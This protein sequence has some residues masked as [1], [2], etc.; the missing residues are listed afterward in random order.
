MKRMRN[1]GILLQM[2]W[3]NSPGYFA[4]LFLGGLVN[5]G[6]V[7]VNVLLPR[8][9][10]DRLTGIDNALPALHWVLLIAGAN[11][12]F[13]LL[14]KTV[15]WRKRL[16]ESQLYLRIDL[17]F[18]AK[19]M[20]IPYHMLEDPY[21][22]DLKERAAFAARG[23]GLVENLVAH[24]LEVVTQLFTV[25]GLVAVM[26]SL[27]WQLIAGLMLCVAVLLLIQLGF[28][29]Y[30]QRFFEELMPFN[31]RYGYYVNLCY[32]Q[33]LQK[34]L[35][36][37]RMQGMLGD[38]ITRYN[39]EINKWY[40]RFNRRMGLAM[41]LFQ[42]VVM[43]QTAL[44]YGLVGMEA[45]Q[46]GIGIGSFTMYVSAAVAFSSAII[47]FGT[48]LIDTGKAV[49]ML[50]PLSELMAIPED[51]ASGA[52]PLGLIERIRFEDVSF[53][54]P[55]TEDAVLQ[56]LSFEIRRGERISIVGRNGAG[57]STIVKLLCRLYEPSAGRI[58][59]NERDIRDYDK[60][61][62]QRAMAAVFQDF[63]LFNF[64]LAENI[65]CDAPKAQD[66]RLERVIRETGL[67]PKIREL[68]RGLSTM[69]GKMY[70]QD[71]VEL[72][73]GQEQKVA[74][75]RALYK[76][77]SLLILDEPTSALDPVA[78]AEVYEQMH[79]MAGE[80]TAIFISHR[81]SSSLFCDRILVLDEG[82]L[83]AFDSHQVLMKQESIYRELFEAQAAHYREAV[84]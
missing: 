5:T 79:R 12:L 29:R 1:I 10:I 2:I 22:L 62:L 51:S 41:G 55:K 70:D 68:P 7:M 38:T 45:L 64:S 6:Q 25:A 27:G 50:A 3:R 69:L 8:Q 43:L 74:L 82:R 30:Q 65:S 60:A 48:A 16:Q 71:A 52:E 57:K 44:A 77:A 23:M 72:S 19:L 54:Y 58:L 56:G 34:D 4:L 84:V 13:A 24:V 17:A 33:K 61:S 39:L 73:G 59:I 63:R 20:S 18:A 9:L 11:L 40:G 67:A 53:S 42:V 80:R 14:R 15:T 49:N 32:D 31:R 83:L 28:S 35:R 81:M 36:L 21:Y 26:L 75:A 66:P 47:A 78:E 76:D 46:G 37:Y